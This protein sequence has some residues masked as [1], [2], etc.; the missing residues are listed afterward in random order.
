VNLC[1]KTPASTLP[2]TK[3]VPTT[4]DGGPGIPGDAEPG[5]QVRSTL[6]GRAS[7]DGGE[8]EV[9]TDPEGELFETPRALTYVWA[10]LILLLTLEAVSEIFGL[11]GPEA[12]YEL[13][14]HDAILVGSAGLIFARAFYEPRGRRAWLAFGSAAALWAIGSIAWNIVYGGLA[15]PPFPTFADVLWLLW[16]PL[17]ALGIF[18]L[19]QIRLPDFEFHRWMDGIAVTLMAL[20]AGFTMV[21]QPVVERTTKG[22]L[23]TVVSFSYPVLDVLL[24]GA[25]LGVYGLLAWHP[26]RMWLLL[27]VGIL[28]STIADAAFAIQQERGIAN[29]NHYDFVWTLGALVIAYAAWVRVPEP[30]GHREQI[31]GMRAI[32]LPLMAQGLAAGIQIYA[33]FEPVG[34]AERIVT[35]AALAV[36]SVQIILSRPR[37]APKGEPAEANG[38]PATVDGHERPEPDSRPAPRVAAR[39]AVEMSEGG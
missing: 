27:G 19:I 33:I 25:I 15:N 37:A 16:Y 26:D 6:E 38:V 29:D 35:L 39:P 2:A 1:P 28:L 8:G 9:R 3:G 4:R 13:W 10:V 23:V 36:A 12:L 31:T 18:F 14:F 21:V 5:A 32:A 34:K 20:V 30:V 11:G 22:L 7:T 24:I 17:T